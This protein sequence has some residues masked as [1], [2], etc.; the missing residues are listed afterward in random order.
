MK[1]LLSFVAVAALAISV[2][3]AGK[4]AGAEGVRMARAEVQ[5]HHHWKPRKATYGKRMRTNFGARCKMSGSC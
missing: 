3:S 1:T 5:H 4:A 2:P